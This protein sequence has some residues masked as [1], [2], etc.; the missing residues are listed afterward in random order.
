[1]V[2]QFT[3]LIENV[4]NDYDRNIELSIILS[5][6]DEDL[7]HVDITYDLYTY[8][9]YAWGVVCVAHYNQTRYYTNL[10]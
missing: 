8:V 2:K 7:L 5:M 3:S 6:Y 9:Y 4:R 10:N 1:M